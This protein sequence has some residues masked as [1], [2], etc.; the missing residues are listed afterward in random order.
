MVPKACSSCPRCPTTGRAEAALSWRPARRLVPLP[1]PW[2]PAAERER[3]LAARGAAL[4]VE[5]DRRGL[6]VAIV[7]SFNFR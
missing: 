4:A 6:E 5:R 2:L 1:V 3:V 7:C